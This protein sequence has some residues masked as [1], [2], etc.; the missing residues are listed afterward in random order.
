MDRD[1]IE[2]KLE[3]LRRCLQRLRDKLPVSAAELA[4][5]PDLQD[6]VALNTNVSTGTSCRRSSNAI[7]LI[8][9]RS[10]QPRPP[11]QT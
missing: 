11:S 4:H 8:S 10:P 2:A 5:D 1:V 6:I 9:T 3:S 7:S